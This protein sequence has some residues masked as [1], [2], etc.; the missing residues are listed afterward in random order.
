MSAV[1]HWPLFGLRV[2]TP[3][4]ELRY[5][6][7]D[8][9]AGVDGCKAGWVVATRAGIRV[10]PTI[11]EVLKSG[12]AVVGIDMPIGM[13]DTSDRAADST[14]RRFLSPRGST[15]FATPVRACLGAADYA[16]ACNRS[17]AACGKKISLQSWHILAKIAEIDAAITAADEQRVIE[18]HPECSFAAMN[19]D[20]VLSSKHTA[21]GLERRTALLET[22]FGALPTTPRGATRDDVLDAYA[23]LWTAERY[24]AGLHREFG[25][26]PQQRDARGLLMRIVL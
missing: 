17:F 6:S 22:H 8:D 21:D 1:E 23:V 20:R 2:R 3:R 13:S 18:V 25:G 24:A 12:H 10:V 14:A 5:P 26:E 11:T 9:I 4:V 19:G 16:D 15:I 7:D